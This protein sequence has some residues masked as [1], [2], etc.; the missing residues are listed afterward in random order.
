MFVPAH[1]SDRF[2]KAASSDA[3]AIILDL[4]DAVPADA[5]HVAAV[6]AL[7]PTAVMPPKTGDLASGDGAMVDEPVRKKALSI[8][9]LGQAPPRT[10]DPP[11]AASMPPAKEI[12]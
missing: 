6:A 8:V 12:T 2:A 11:Q 9:R 3:D 5:K 7:R 1:R 4:E 10:G